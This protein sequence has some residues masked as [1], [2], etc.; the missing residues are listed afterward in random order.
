MRGEV[1]LAV[2]GRRARSAAAPD[3]GTVFRRQLPL[4]LRPVESS[5][6]ANS[7]DAGTLSVNENV[8]PTGGRF[9]LA[10]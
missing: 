10:S 2:A 6:K 4:T 5:L 3:P 9:P 7:S 8:V 1:E